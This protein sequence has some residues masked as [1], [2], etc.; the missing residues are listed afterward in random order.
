MPFRPRSVLLLAFYSLLFPSLKLSEGRASLRCVGMASD[1][2]PSVYPERCC[3][4]K[5]PPCAVGEKALVKDGG[6]A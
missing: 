2:N 5:P 6:K 4:E 1:G 3:Y